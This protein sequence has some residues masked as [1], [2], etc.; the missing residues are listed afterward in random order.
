MRLL[1]NMENVGFRPMS[2][3]T[4]ADSSGNLQK[5]TRKEHPM[6]KFETVPRYLRLALVGLFAGVL[7]VT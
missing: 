5:L 4:R 1:L 7:S 6:P 2:I 3:Q